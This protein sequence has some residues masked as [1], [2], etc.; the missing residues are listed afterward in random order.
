MIQLFVTDLDGTLLK[1]G[2]NLS[3]GVSER[4]IKAVKKLL[5]HH[6]TFSVATARS[7]T[8]QP[9]LEQL[10]GLYIDYI[11]SNGGEIV[12][13]HSL[14]QCD[15]ISYSVLEEVH[16]HMH[17]QNCI[18]NMIYQDFN[19]SAYIEDN[20]RFPFRDREEI[21][22]FESFHTTFPDF[23]RPDI[24]DKVLHFG[25]F[26]PPEAI[27]ELTSYFSKKY[28]DLCVFRSDV[29]FLTF[30]PKGISKGAGVL[31]L[32]QKLQISTDNIAVI[33]DNENDISMFEVTK[34]SFAMSHASEDVKAHAKYVVDDVAEA[35]E[36]VL[37]KL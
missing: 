37:D 10:L 20:D 24:P 1:I 4:N 9:E 26:C 19:G 32:A 29:D 5:D 27:P 14:D 36:I 25:V 7:S 31:K 33:G 11:G 28:P 12:F 16:H 22:H 8:Y 3:A 21:S 13:D 18:H 23:N 35:I 30:M 2:N 15:G 6:I 17:E 34:Y